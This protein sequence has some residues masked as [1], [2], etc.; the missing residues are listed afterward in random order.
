M[1]VQEKHWVT[2]LSVHAG[3]PAN[4]VMRDFEIPDQV[5]AQFPSLDTLNLDSG[6]HDEKELLQQMPNILER[7]GTAI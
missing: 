6:S 5:L 4:F 1:S 2:E 3:N 7:A